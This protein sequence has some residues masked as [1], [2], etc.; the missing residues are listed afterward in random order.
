[1]DTQSENEKTGLLEQT[2]VH[3]L[4]YLLKIKKLTITEFARQINIPRGTINNIINKKVVAPTIPVIHKIAKFFDITIDQMVKL[5]LSDQFY[6]YIVSSGASSN[7]CLSRIPILNWHDAYQAVPQVT[8]TDKRFEF[9]DWLEVG[10]LISGN[11]I[12]F[13]MRSKSSYEPKFPANAFLIFDRNVIP[14]DNHYVLVSDE[15]KAKISLMQYFYDG[16]NE[17]ICSLHED[18]K[19]IFDPQYTTFLGVLSFVKLELN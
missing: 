7:G 4:L 10:K 15:T 5:K 8:V 1:M 13:A 17:Y 14:A 16:N 18:Q 6:F 19:N 9:K 12:L 11:N 3:N 2:I